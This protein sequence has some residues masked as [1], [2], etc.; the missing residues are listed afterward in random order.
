M[1]GCRVMEFSWVCVVQNGERIIICLHIHVAHKSSISF[2]IYDLDATNG[3]T[4]IILI[5]E[6]KF[7]VVACE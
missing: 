7:D 6:C 4:E 1:H 3:M 5:L 2:S